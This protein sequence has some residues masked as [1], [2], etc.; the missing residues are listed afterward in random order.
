MSIPSSFF[1]HTAYAEDQPFPYLILST[2]VLSRGFQTGALFGS[3][4]ATYRHYSP[5]ASTAIPRPSLSPNLIRSTGVG[6]VAGIALM[7]FGLEARMWGRERIEWED[8]SWR[9]LENKGQVECDT[10][11]AEGAVVGAGLVAWKQGL[12]ASGWR[13]LAGGAGVGGLVGVLG[14]MGWRYGVKR[15]Q[16]EEVAVKT[17]EEVN[18]VMPVIEGRGEGALGKE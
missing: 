9:L 3:L 1:P 8:R 17:L 14:Y 18:P 11:S 10:F 13:M 7:V 5:R 2:H 16:W 15:G 4:A 12:R 6:G